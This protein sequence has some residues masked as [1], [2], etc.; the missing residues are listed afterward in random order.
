MKAM[1][2]SHDTTDWKET[3]MTTMALAAGAERV[4]DTVRPWLRIEGLAAFLAGL[5]IYATAG[6]DW[7]W[8]LPLLLLPDLSMVG[9]LGGPALGSFTYNLVH[10]WAVGLALLGAGLALGAGPLV[11]VGAVLVAHV[12]LDRLAGYGLKHVEGFKDTHLQRA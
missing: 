5:A 9:Y 6:G 12:G 3:A 1:Y 8:F 10:N 7:L 4:P 2:S 11:I